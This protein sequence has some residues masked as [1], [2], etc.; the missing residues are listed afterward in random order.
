MITVVLKLVQVVLQVYHLIQTLLAA[1]SM[2]NKAGK[3]LTECGHARKP[4]AMAAEGPS[5]A[6]PRFLVNKRVQSLDTSS[7]SER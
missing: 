5:K 4:C 6:N 2:R 3:Y 7:Q 1:I